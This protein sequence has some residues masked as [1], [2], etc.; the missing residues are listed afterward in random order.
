MATLY[1][2]DLRERI[3]NDYDGGYPIDDL[4]V[5]YAVSRS[6]LYS[7]IKQRRESGSIA[8]RI[9]RPGKKKKLSP[10]EQ[11]VRQVVAEHHDATLVD[12]CAELSEQNIVVSPTTLCN[13]LRHLK[14][15]RKKR[16][17][18]PQGHWKTT[19]FLAALRHDGF[20]IEN[21]VRKAMLRNVEELWKKLGKL[22]EVFSQEKCKNY[23][24]NAEYKKSTK[25]QTIS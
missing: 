7:L 6:W 24:K 20:Q 15:T 5:H 17:S 23:F 10:H 4:V 11:T 13:F 22:C 21:L 8:P 9:Y 25:V 18:V 3:M 14:I 1:S 12:F 19:T 16:L 2:L